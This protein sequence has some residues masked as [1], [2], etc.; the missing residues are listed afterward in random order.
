MSKKIS[1]L[2]WTS[3]GIWHRQVVDDIPEEDSGNGVDDGTFSV[4]PVAEVQLALVVLAD[5]LLHR[6]EQTLLL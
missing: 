1:Y 6:A 4:Q 2:M 3:E 5:K